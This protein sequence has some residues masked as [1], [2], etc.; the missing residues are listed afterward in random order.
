MGSVGRVGSRTHARRDTDQEASP[1]TGLQG[2]VVC[3]QE[4]YTWS[5]VPTPSCTMSGEVSYSGASVGVTG[6]KLTDTH[7]THVPVS[8][9]Y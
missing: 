5:R 8:L 9:G 3:V 4:K 6:G 1:E 2:S 7:S